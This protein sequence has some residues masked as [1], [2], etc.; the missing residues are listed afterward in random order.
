MLSILKKRN[1]NPRNFNIEVLAYLWVE[2][3]E[4]TL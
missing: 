1:V 2:V 4:P 3:R